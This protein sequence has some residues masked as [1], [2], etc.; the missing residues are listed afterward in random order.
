MATK[1]LAR[2][3]IEGGR[4]FHNCDERRE[5]HRAVRAR[6]RDALAATRL[7]PE[8][9]EET[10]DVRTKHV[11]RMF[12]DKLS[13][14]YRF[15]DSRVGKPWDTTRSLIAQR[16]DTRTTAGRH[17]VFDHLLPSI[18]LERGCL[19]ARPWCSYFVDDDGMLQNTVCKR[20][21]HAVMPALPVAWL[22][23]RKLGRMGGLLAWFVPRRD[24]E[25]VIAVATGWCITYELRT[26]GSAAHIGFRQSSS[27]DEDERAYFTSFPER[28]QDAVLAASPVS[29]LRGRDHAH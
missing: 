23:N 7:D 6:L 17:I 22:G 25:N 16:F 13:P 12:H 28:V 14:A 19:V 5:S 18:A 2:S 1:D 27:L 8:E 9:A 29:K 3:V 24:A 15:L 10:F 20:T 11:G 21:R 4:Y 26:G